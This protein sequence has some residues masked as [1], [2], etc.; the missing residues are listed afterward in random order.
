MLGGD[1]L[2]FVCD[3]RLALDLAVTVLREVERHKIPHLSEDRGGKTLTACAGVALV[4]VRAPFHRSYE[5]AEGLC[6]LA[7]RRRRE[8][9]Q[10][11]GIE[12]GCWLDWHVGTTRPGESVDEIR[13][14]QYKRNS[15]TMRP[16]PLVK[17]G[18]RNESWD[19]LDQ[20]LL[21]PVSVA[22]DSFRGFREEFNSWSGSRN[23][24]KRLMS[25]VSNGKDEID[26]Q[27]K[28]WRVTEPK[29][30]MPAGLQDGGFIGS[31]TPLLDA[32]ELMDLHL[33]LDPIRE[34]TDSNV[35][36]V[37]DGVIGSSARGDGLR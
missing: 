37:T 16:Y 21:G 17:S 33:R 31:D 34:E 24:V 25:L 8:E 26:R 11:D 2:T 14:R 15:L 36:V 13:E 29:L 5:L 4:K 1:D 28:A 18:S 3:G 27:I 32:I 30:Q 35:A 19:W 7:K 12:T 6:Q 23:R 22:N 20:E 10:K 9:N